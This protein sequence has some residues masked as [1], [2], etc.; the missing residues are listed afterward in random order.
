MDEISIAL[1]ILAILVAVVAIFVNYLLRSASNERVEIVREANLERALDDAST[2]F[3]QRA[4]IFNVWDDPDVEIELIAFA[5]DGIYE[6]TI[7]NVGDKIESVYE[8][9]LDDEGIAEGKIIPFTSSK[10]KKS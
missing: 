8:R 10:Q 5:D 1:S 4:P 6:V 9:P 7:E 3:L 2:L